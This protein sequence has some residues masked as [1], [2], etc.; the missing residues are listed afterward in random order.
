MT[1]FRNFK[2]VPYKFGKSN[3]YALH[4]N[5]LQYSDL[6]DT[7]RDNVAFYQKYTI[8]DGDRP[9][10]LSFKLYGSTKYY[11][12]FFLMN[13]KLRE[14]GWPLDNYS[15]LQTVQSERA[16]TVLTTRDDLTSIF[17]VGS[18]VA[19]QSSGATGTI[20]D[21]R[22]DYG[23]LIV[24]GIKDF[25]SNEDITTTEN[26]VLNSATLVGSVDQYEATWQY[27]DSDGLP[28]DVN[29]YASP[30]ASYNAISYYDRYVRENDSL[31][32][33]VVIKPNS[34][35]AVFEKF[36]QSMASF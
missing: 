16:N 12:T 18:V 34:I 20:I 31:K 30:P 36:Q 24:R 22:L 15:I 8:M 2:F 6:V 27:E 28:V 10:T 35:G 11:W 32:D 21:R 23:Q 29:P 25:I 3:E 33:I 1:Y 4:Q 13:N 19:G 26:G 14:R 9:D 7:V 17:N 5:L